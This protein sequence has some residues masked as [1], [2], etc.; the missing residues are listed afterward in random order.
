MEVAF[1]HTIREAFHRRMSLILLVVCLVTAIYYVFQVRFVTTPD[2]QVVVPTVMD[3]PE[4][5]PDGRVVMRTVVV[6]RPVRSFMNENLPGQLNFTG[7]FWLILGALSAVPLVTSFHE[8]GWVG[9]LVSKRVARW[10]LLLG[11]YLA[12]LV[13][14]AV[15]LLLVCGVP[16]LHVWLGTGNSTAPFLKGVGLILFGYACTLAFSTLL[17]VL[18]PNV[19][20]VA[21]VTF[22]QLGLSPLLAQRE[23]QFKEHPALR[24]LAD[25]LYWVLPKNDELRVM[26]IDMYYGT[27][28]DSWTP[29][30]ASA[31]VLVVSLS[32]ACLIFQRKSL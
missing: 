18:Q 3:R 14:F 27:A 7:F 26:A 30:W 28:V 4:T 9:L 16:A 11:R 25:F 2:G 15:A 17:A 29:L 22:V 21:V 24:G 6:E 31:I 10:E 20:L 1:L 32:A 23:D 19:G 13:Q 8:T 5:T 12:A